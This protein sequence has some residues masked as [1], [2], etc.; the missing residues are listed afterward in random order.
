MQHYEAIRELIDR[1]RRRW[2]TLRTFEAIVRAS[3]A[4]IVVVGVALTAALST[5]GRPGAL[6]TIGIVAVLLTVAAVVWGLLPLRRV[7]DDRHV[8]R[9]IEEHTPTLDDRLVSAV[10]LAAGDR[11]ATPLAGPML[12]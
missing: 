11:P 10:D 1:V 8:A 2:R 4:A 12:A 7:P 9:F 3:A 5:T 6:A